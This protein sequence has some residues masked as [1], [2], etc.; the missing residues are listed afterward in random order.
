MS[1]ARYIS[2]N[3]FAGPSAQRRV[4]SCVFWSWFLEDGKV[5]FPPPSQRALGTKSSPVRHAHSPFER[6]FDW[7]FR[8]SIFD[9]FFDEIF[10]RLSLPK[11]CPNGVKIDQKSDFFVDCRWKCF[12]QVSSRFLSSFLHQPLDLRTSIFAIP[13]SVFEGFFTFQKIA[14]RTTSKWFLTS[15]KLQK[16]VQN[17]PKLVPETQKKQHRRKIRFFIFVS[18]KLPPKGSPNI[19]QN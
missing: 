14:S 2:Y 12:F 6:C 18:P 17:R 5:P 4:R 13:Y 1:D 16:T 15:Q 9:S 10:H 11:W 7:F 3:K 8:V 19:D